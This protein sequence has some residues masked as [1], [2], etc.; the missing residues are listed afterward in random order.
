MFT[1]LFD[2]AN[3]SAS[4]RKINI[5]FKYII[6][7]KGMILEVNFNV[8]RVEI[9]VPSIDSEPGDQPLPNLLFCSSKFSD[10]QYLRLFVCGSHHFIV[11]LLF[12]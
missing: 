6:F 1:V 7:N 8:G 9:F 10:E 2:N 5:P 11:D 12:V 3:G 4:W